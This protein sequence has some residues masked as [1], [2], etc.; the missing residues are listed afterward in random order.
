MNWP[1]ENGLRLFFVV[2]FCLSTASKVRDLRA[3]SRGV[4]AYRLVPR[5]L[6]LPTTYAIVVLEAATPLALIVRPDLGWPLTVGLLVVFTAAQLRAILRGE[7]I[8]CHCLNSSD[9]IDAGTVLRSLWFLT[10]ALVGGLLSPYRST[11]SAADVIAASI[12]LAIAAY[13]SIL[14]TAFVQLKAVVVE[15]LLEE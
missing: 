4:A 8:A 5:R 3:F 1:I 2:L 9:R 6:L 15:Q 11:V 14:P 12:V 7:Q 10:A 13:G